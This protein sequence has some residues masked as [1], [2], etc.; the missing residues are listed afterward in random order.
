M[1][2]T[3]IRNESRIAFSQVR[4]RRFGLIAFDSMRLPNNGIKKKRE[5]TKITFQWISKIASDHGE[6]K[7]ELTLLADI[8]LTSKW[9]EIID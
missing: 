7:G 4:Y 6:I 5:K 3:A 1:T 2:I 8:I 9:P